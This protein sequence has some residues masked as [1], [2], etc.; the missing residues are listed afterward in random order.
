MIGAPSGAV[1]RALSMVQAV[2]E[3]KGLTAST[4]KARYANR[5]TALMLPI[6]RDAAGGNH[7]LDDERQDSWSEEQELA[8][9]RG[10]PGRAPHGARRRFVERLWHSVFE[11]SAWS[12]NVR[13]P[14]SAQQGAVRAGGVSE[15]AAHHPFSGTAPTASGIPSFDGT[16]W[17]TN[18]TIEGELSQASPAM[19]VFQNA[20]HLLHIGNSSHRIYHLVFDGVEWQR[21]PDNEGL[22]NQKQGARC[23]RR[24]QRRAAHGTSRRHLEPSLAY[25]LQRRSVVRERSNPGPVEQVATGSRLAERDAAPVASR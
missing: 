17:T 8:R 20:L 6:V 3:D 9:P 2:E 14:D 5:D 22:E 10:L 24:L 23:A 15:S 21:R 18:V 19:A 1:V 11:G 7:A 4:A 13:I 25:A 12:Q 16:R